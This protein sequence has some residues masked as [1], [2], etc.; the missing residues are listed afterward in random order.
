MKIL[1]ISDIHA[2]SKARDDGSIPSYVKAGDSAFDS[3]TVTFE[4]ILKSGGLPKPDL[5]VCPG[6]LCDCA[7]SSGLSYACEFL[8]RVAK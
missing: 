4:Q 2:F 5:I 6:D 8:K 1:V 3:P 7:D